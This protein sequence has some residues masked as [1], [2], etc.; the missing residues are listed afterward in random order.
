[1]SKDILSAYLEYAKANN[2]KAPKN[3]SNLLEGE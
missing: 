1:L 2:I 3:A